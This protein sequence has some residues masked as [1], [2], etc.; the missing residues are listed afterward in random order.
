MFRLPS[1][2]LAATAL[3]V[4]VAPSTTS[5]QFRLKPGPCPKTREF[6]IPEMKTRPADGG[7]YQQQRALARMPVDRLIREFGGPDRA[8]AVARA[9]K[10]NAQQ[11]LASGASG[12]AARYWHDTVLRADALLLIL[13]CRA[14]GNS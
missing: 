13:E 12:T 1:L 14:R 4:S 7:A 2:A 8:G 5:A 10:R 3:A 9:T 11:R 6:I